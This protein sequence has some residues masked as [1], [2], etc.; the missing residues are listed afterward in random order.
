MLWLVLAG[1]IGGILAG[2]LGIGGGII[3]VLILPYAL[4]GAGI[5]PEYLAQFTIANSIFGVLF[6]S[7]TTNYLNIRNHD[8]YLKEAFWVG[9]PGATFAVLILKTIVTQPWFSVSYFYGVL[10]LFLGYML[11]SLFIKK[12]QEKKVPVSK[13]KE[14]KLSLAG[15]AGGALAAATGLGG[16]AAAVPILTTQL[17]MNIKKA[18]SISLF[19]IFITAL[20]LTIFN[21]LEN[22]GIQNLPYQVGYI[23]FPTAL[24]VTIGVLLGSPIGSKLGRMWSSKTIKI[25]F[26]IFILIVMVEKLIQLLNIHIG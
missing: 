25:L 12:D 26:G 5:L 4:E 23:Y 22:P 1:F 19:M 21:L 6:A 20:T 8:F 9:I 10:V 16:G 13:N 17:H 11:I 3:Y 7:L 24:P 2:L 15:M 14:L 18:R